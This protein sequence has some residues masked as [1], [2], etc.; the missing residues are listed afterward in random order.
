MVKTKCC[1][2]EICITFKDTNMLEVKRW[3]K[4]TMQY[5]NQKVEWL[6]W[7]NRL[8]NKQMLLETKEELLNDNS[9]NKL[10]ISKS[11]CIYK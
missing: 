1:L 9:F 10:G 7:Q 4:Y 8:K 11:R 5:I 6:Y 2:R 3:K